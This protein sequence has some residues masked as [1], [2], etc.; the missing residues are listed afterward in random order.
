MAKPRVLKDSRASRLEAHKRMMGRRKG[1]LLAQFE[2]E[3]D[4]IREGFYARKYAENL[5]NVKNPPF[6]TSTGFLKRECYRLICRFRRIAGGYR[7]I[8]SAA[9]EYLDKPIEKVEYKDNPFYW[10][11]AAIFPDRDELS[12]QDLSKFAAQLL[13]ADRNNVE[14]QHLIGF[15]YQ[16]GGPRNL[17]ERL[18]QSRPDE[19]LV[20]TPLA[21][22]P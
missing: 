19:S 22:A 2:E 10:G 13:Y 4:L 17:R 5:A 16:T 14:T 8:T 6:D 1:A 12:A 20:L 3:A 7:A 9:S 18:D 11:L 15:L 21:R